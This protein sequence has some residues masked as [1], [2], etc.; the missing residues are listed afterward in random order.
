MVAKSF[1]EIVFCRLTIFADQLRAACRAGSEESHIMQMCYEDLTDFTK[2]VLARIPLQP[3]CEKVKFLVGDLLR[4]YAHSLES[5]LK[6]VR[7][8]QVVEKQHRGLRALLRKVSLLAQH[9]QLDAPSCNWFT[10]K[11]R[12]AYLKY[13][14]SSET[15][16]SMF[17]FLRVSLFFE[18]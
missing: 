18:I 4:R 7:E 1:L 3:P 13:E 12:Q 15:S 5:G 9:V 17:Q 10:I 2:F 8:D 6:Q 11:Q 14:F 16:L